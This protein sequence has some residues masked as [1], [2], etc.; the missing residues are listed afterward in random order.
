MQIMQKWRNAINGNMHYIYH[1]LVS[2]PLSKCCL[3]VA[4][5]Q[6]LKQTKYEYHHH[7]SVFKTSDV[8]SCP[9]VSFSESRRFLS[10]K[11]S[12]RPVRTSDT[13]LRVKVVLHLL[14]STDPISTVF[15][16]SNIFTIQKLLFDACCIIFLHQLI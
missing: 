6:C 9:K 16:L 4:C 2:L 8:M 1:K 15:K 10:R 11:Y 7:L 13:I 3:I 5:M 12:A 14:I